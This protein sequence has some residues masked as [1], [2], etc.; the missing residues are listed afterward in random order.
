[1]LNVPTILMLLLVISHTMA[2]MFLKQK[3]ATL[4]V[5][6]ADGAARAKRMSLIIT[7]L[8]V[9]IPFITALIWF[10]VAPALA[11]AN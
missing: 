1:M 9:E 4:D 5:T 2:I 6:T 8:Y 11:P 10:V 3:R 7:I